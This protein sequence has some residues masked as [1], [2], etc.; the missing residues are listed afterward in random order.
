MPRIRPTRTR[1][2]LYPSTLPA[3]L[4]AG[5]LLIPVLAPAGDLPPASGSCAWDTTL[6]DPGGSLNQFGL[7]GDDLY[8]GGSANSDFNGVDNGVAAVDL[9][10]G[11]VSPLGTT[12]LTDGF[13][14]GLVPYDDGNGERLFIAGAFNAIEFDG[15][16][17]PDSRGVVAWDGSETVTLPGSPY[18]EPLVFAQAATTWNGQ[19][20]V[21]GAGGAIDPPQL[22]V[23][24]L[25]DGSEWTV[26]RN[27]FSG[28]VAPVVLAVEEYDGDL[29]FGGRFDDIDY[30]EGNLVESMN[31]M[32]F[33]GENFFSVDGGLQRATSPIS[34]VLAMKAFDDGSGE[35]LYI[36]GR[37]DSSVDGD[38]MLAVAKW[39]GT[40]LT[41]VGNGFPMPTE[42][43]GFEVYDDGGGPALYA[44][45]NFTEDTEGNA[46]SRIARLEDGQWREVA[47]G[48]GENPNKSLALPDGSLSFAG[49]FTDVGGA[50]GTPGAGASS[51]FAQLECLA[52]L[53][54][55]PSV[56]DF[57]TLG[58][59]GSDTVTLT[60]TN[61]TDGDNSISLTEIIGD[62][63][64]AI[65]GTDTCSG[66]TLGAGESCQVEAAFTPDGQEG[67]FSGGL[68][69]AG[70]TSA[71]RAVLSGTAQVGVASTA[72]PVLDARGLVLLAL[73]IAGIAGVILRGRT[74]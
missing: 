56:H 44:V 41:A 20:V 33:D 52:D 48:A 31:I 34:Q 30:P 71:A 40:E 43:R 2:I 36:G 21:A 11:T 55:S 59:T 58:T 60:V 42:V 19:L 57:G 4:A 68:R 18:A 16:E 63:V 62:G 64:F 67:D 39:D 49:N 13:V 51:G 5:L 32:G 69:V 72:I 74:S 46:I 17:L 10:A 27:E 53:T 23:L 37:F 50:S 66:T 15:E 14:T 35:A 24:S 45:G 38:P 1:K 12:R 8:V 54:V 47:G 6:G 25:W 3:I 22:P 65:G 73:L 9:D 28:L 7:W 61:E 70:E 26:F 29:Y